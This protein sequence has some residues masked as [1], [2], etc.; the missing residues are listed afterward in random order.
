MTVGKFMCGIAAVIYYSTDNTFLLL[1]RAAS[2]DAGANE[3]ESVTGRVDQGESF[4]QALH[5]EVYE[6]LHTTATIEFLI[7]TTHFYRGAVS[8]ENE[9]LGV[10]YFCSINDPSSIVISDEHSEYR[11]LTLQQ[12]QELL[13]EAHWLRQTIQQAEAMRSLLPDE[14]LY[15]Y[16][17][18]FAQ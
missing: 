8:P 17:E 3:W 6:E 18:I 1:K 14:L 10:R 9:L 12:V 4:E 16:H 13:P 5:R 15:L 11:W 2:K 7:G